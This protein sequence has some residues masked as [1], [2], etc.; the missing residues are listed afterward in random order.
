MLEVAALL[1]SLTKPPSLAMATLPSLAKAAAF[2]PAERAVDNWR[3]QAAFDLDL[4]TDTAL[5][6]LAGSNPA[7]LP[8]CIRL[9]NY[10]CIKKAGWTGEIA[11]DQE[12][13][14]AFASAQQGAV[15]AVLLLRRYYVEYGR[16]SARAIIAH[17][18]PAQ[19]G[20]SVAAGSARTPSG[21]QPSTTPSLTSLAKYG[22][23]NTLRAR[24]L[25]G[26]RRGGAPIARR[27]TGKVAVKRS[28]VP[29]R[30]A[31][32]MPTPNMA[33][34]MGSRE[35]PLQLE[36]P[37]TGEPLR[38]ASASLPGLSR[39]PVAPPSP[40]LGPSSPSL[41]PPAPPSATC[42]ADTTRLANYAARAIEGI[43]RSPDEDLKLFDADGSPLPSLRRGLANMAG[44]EIGPYRAD[45]KL[46][47]A[48]IETVREAHAQRQTARK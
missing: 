9:N 25:A 28:V 45:A 5:R 43:A 21:P 39:T 16:K 20:L 14:V 10:W 17:W 11:S 13:H 26:R 8:R 34:R 2:Q 29:D 4:S 42:V 1:L 7:N 27:G 41:I 40:L 35:P 18:A 37:L 23:A 32:T 24:W 38:V 36:P 33:L 30:L 3:V 47:D 15:V 48:A 46:I 6:W 31:S 12:G 22:I 19:C 44:V